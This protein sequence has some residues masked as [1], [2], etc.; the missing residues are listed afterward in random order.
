MV[1]RNRAGHRKYGMISKN[2]RARSRYYRQHHALL[3]WASTYGRAKW[4]LSEGSQMRLRCIVTQKSIPLVAGCF[5]YFNENCFLH[6]WDICCSWRSNSDVMFSK[7][8]FS[9]SFVANIKCR[10]LLS[11]CRRGKF[12]ADNFQIAPLLAKTGEEIDIRRSNYSNVLMLRYKIEG[13]MS[14]D[15]I[16]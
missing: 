13:I 9:R 6:F 2:N 8:E 7:R 3:F 16:M 10:A 11:L 5:K 1:I 12:L 14:N 4:I 15:K